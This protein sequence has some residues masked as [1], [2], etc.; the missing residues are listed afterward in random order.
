LR[1]GAGGGSRG[2]RRPLATA[3]GCP[4]R[5]HEG[6]RV[7][8]AALT[9]QEEERRARSAL[10]AL[11]KARRARRKA[12]AARRRARPRRIR[13]VEAR[14]DALGREYRAA[15]TREERRRVRAELRALGA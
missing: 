12:A 11:E 13:E 2:V 3:R 15:E 9:P 5:A 1:A 7:T 14:M 6:G 10:R 4:L 8:A